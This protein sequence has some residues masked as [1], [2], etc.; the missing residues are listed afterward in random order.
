[1]AK[2]KY[3][4]RKETPVLPKTIRQGKSKGVKRDEVRWKPIQAILD[5]TAA[6][7]AE[8]DKLAA[9][10]DMRSLADYPVFTK[11]KRPPCTRCGATNFPQMPTNDGARCYDAGACEKRRHHTVTAR[12]A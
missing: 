4:R 2:V 7:H 11:K 9:G 5:R 10:A 3:K 1:M 8:I 12:Y 6:A